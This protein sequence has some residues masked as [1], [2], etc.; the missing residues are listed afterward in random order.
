[1]HVRSNNVQRL[2]ICVCDETI[3]GGFSFPKN[4]L[5]DADAV[6]KY[7][8]TLSS[9]ITLHLRTHHCLRQKATFGT[10]SSDKK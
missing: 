10:E 8:Q 2:H 4:L 5:I 9:I 3:F 7:L 1:M 6:C